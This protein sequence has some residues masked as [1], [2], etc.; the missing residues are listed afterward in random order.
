MNNSALWVITSL[1]VLIIVA[2]SA[3]VVIEWWQTHKQCD[4]MDE[5]VR[6]GRDFDNIH[7]KCVHCGRIENVEF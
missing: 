5:Y 1:P 6:I 3:I 2:V 4:H 7:V